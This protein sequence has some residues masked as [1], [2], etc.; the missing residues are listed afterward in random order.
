MAKYAFNKRTEV[1]TQTM[2]RKLKKK[3]IRAVAWSATWHSSETWTMRENEF[4]R[5]Q[6]LECGYG[7]EWSRNI[8]K[9][10]WQMNR[11]LR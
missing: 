10:R 5:L 3:I 9:L 7:V 8:G 4:D 6:V 1:L 2:D 11:Y